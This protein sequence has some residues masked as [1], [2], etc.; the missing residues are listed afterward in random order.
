MLVSSLSI[1]PLFFLFTSSEERS[2]S[3]EIG[4]GNIK[5]TDSK[6]KEEEEKNCYQ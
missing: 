5:T 4:M 1:F 3:K 2:D 6:K